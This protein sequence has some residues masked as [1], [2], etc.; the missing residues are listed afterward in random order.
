MSRSKAALIG[1]AL[2]GI[3]ALPASAEV[4]QPVCGIHQDVLQWFKHAYSE[5]P[6]SIGLTTNGAVIEVLKS[7]EGTWTIVMTQPN[8][9]SCLMAAG[10]GWQEAD[11]PKGVKL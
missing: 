9:V 8:S 11:K 4:Q 6:V 5:T 3:A 2:V 1:A 10:E 7:P